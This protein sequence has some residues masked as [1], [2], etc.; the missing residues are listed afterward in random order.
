MGLPNP[1]VV[2][3]GWQGANWKSIHPLVDAG[4]MPNLG[5]LIERG[6][7]GNLRASGPG[8]PAVLW[9]SV[10]TGKTADQHG[11]LSALDCDPLSG[12]LRLAR[13]SNRRAK[14]IW[15][16]AMQSG[17]VAHVAG[18]YA[19]SPAEEL[20]G[21]SVSAEFVIPSLRAVGPVRNGTIYPQR[22]AAHA[23]E[24]RLHIREL[25]ANE[26]LPFIPTLDA[27][28][29]TKDIRVAALADIL[30][31]EIS[32]HAIVT[33][34]METEPWNLMTIGW[35]A[36]GRACHRF[37]QYAAPRMPDVNEEDCA[38]FGGVVTEMYRFHDMLLGRLME[39]AGTEATFVIVSPA[40]YRCGPERPT[41]PDL[42]RL[43][44]AWY[45]P[46]GVLCMA[47]P[48]IIQDELVHGAS[49]LD[50]APSVLS[51]LGLA[52]GADMPGRV[53]HEAFAQPPEAARIPS[54]EAVPG[55]CGMRAPESEEDEKAAAAAVAELLGEGYAEPVRPPSAAAAYVQRERLLNTVLIHLAAGRYQEAR[56]ALLELAAKSPQDLRIRLWLAHCQMVWGDREACREAMRGIPR[57]GADGALV[58]LIE[59]QLEAAE[60]NVTAALAAI[61]QAELLGPELPIVNY[62]AA[63]MYMRLRLWERAEKRLRR[64]VTLDPALQSAHTLLSRL[65]FQR[66]DGAQA[67]ESAR[68]S[69]EIDYA[70]ALS[71]LAFG[72]AM[73]GTGQGDQALGAF[74]KS[75]ALDPS[76][77]EAGAWVTIIKAE[78]QARASLANPESMA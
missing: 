8:D 21:S 14:A 39:L 53:I 70:S 3:I 24:L 50:V 7:I 63:I 64:A 78:R 77:E 6:V 35:H 65:Q 13:G 27:I 67:A 12:K 23:A 75:A 25:A 36:L 37:M 22:L 62:A 4:L 15:N 11:I 61:T 72:F 41:A 55:D 68:N 10:A 74:E 20:N 40:G 29:Q 76:L 2:V 66:G 1:K 60:G 69:L 9:T 31:R 73:V 71:H 26:L 47:G 59:T 5:S 57:E 28:D 42:R 19:A 52:P 49:A 33:W 43:P 44:G 32:M 51:I 56:P 58:C 48:N 46:Y 30:A 34:L 17:L 54:W 16:I 18:W 38:G 45:K